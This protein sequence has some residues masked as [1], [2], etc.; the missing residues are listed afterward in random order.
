LVYHPF[1]KFRRKVYLYLRLYGTFQNNICLYPNYYQTKKIFQLFCFLPQ[2]HVSMLSATQF[3]TN[4]VILF[5]FLSIAGIL[6]LTLKWRILP[7]LCLLWIMWH[8]FLTVLCYFLFVGAYPTTLTGVRP[9]ISPRPTTGF[10][11]APDDSRRL[12]STV[13]S[14][15]VV[16]RIDS[17][18]LK[19]FG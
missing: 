12:V 13:V 10:A 19:L 1:R 2:I 4:F 15:Y 6:I 7:V 9:A 5:L 3:G 18:K 8:R 14:S 16:W 17:C 11:L